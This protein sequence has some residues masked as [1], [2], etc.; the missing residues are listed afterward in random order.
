MISCSRG[1]KRV[2]CFVVEALV[3]QSR[4][5][6]R[7]LEFAWVLAFDRLQ[8]LQAERWQNQTGNRHGVCV[9]IAGVDK[10]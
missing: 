2:G 5:L 7:V 10:R 8:A 3:V 9:S 1:A 6:E 4:V